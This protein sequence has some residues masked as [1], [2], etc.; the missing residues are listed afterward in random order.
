MIRTAKQPAR[1]TVQAGLGTTPDRGIIQSLWI[2]EPANCDL[3]CPY[4]FCATVGNVRDDDRDNLAWDPRRPDSYRVD[5]YVANILRPFAKAIVAWNES[6]PEERIE[7]FDCPPHQADDAQI[8]GKVAIPGAGEPFHPENL[9]LT[10]ALLKHAAALDLHMTLFTSGHLITDELAAELAPQDVVLLVKCNSR[11]PAVQNELVGQAPNG[12]FCSMRDAALERLMR[13]G[14]NEP[15]GEPG[16]PTYQETRLGIVT[17]V[18]EDNLGELPDLLRFARRNNIIF[19]CDTIL[20]RGRGTRCPEIPSDE[21]TR[22][23]F[24]ELQRIDRKEFDKHWDISRSYI[25]TTCDRFRHHLYVDKRGYI[26][27]CVGCLGDDASGVQP[28]ILGNV[29]DGPGALYAAWNTPLMRDIIRRHV[30]AGPCAT[31]LNYVEEKCYSCLGRCRNLEVGMESGD[32]RNSVSMKGCWNN[33][34]GPG[35]E[36]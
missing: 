28:V 8:R 10:R 36:P 32:G 6:T 18:M 14:F 17:S 16:S 33:R 1:Q 5:L 7:R 3:Q 12:S 19:D 26:Y 9:H 29:K 30:Y 35:K 23:A 13:F 11:N 27:P 4:C 34:P 24:N 21:K 15:Y 31:C 22:A 2:E 25:G 20:E